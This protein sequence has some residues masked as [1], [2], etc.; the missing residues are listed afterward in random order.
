MEEFLLVISVF[1]PVEATR[2]AAGARRSACCEP[3]TDVLLTLNV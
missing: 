3:R 1:V 2:A